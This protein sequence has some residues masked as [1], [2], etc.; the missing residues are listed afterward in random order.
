MK[1][2]E[3]TPV[4]WGKR[5]AYRKEPGDENAYSAAADHGFHYEICP[6]CS[7]KKQAQK[8]YKNAQK[9]WYG[10]KLPRGWEGL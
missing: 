4:C 9:Q 6:K 5:C 8:V 3:K 7:N 1:S 10:G 2:K